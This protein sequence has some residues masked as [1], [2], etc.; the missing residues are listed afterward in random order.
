MGR[1]F[2]QED[3]DAYYFIIITLQH[4]LAVEKMMVRLQDLFRLLFLV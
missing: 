1:N 3:R 4:C 2:V